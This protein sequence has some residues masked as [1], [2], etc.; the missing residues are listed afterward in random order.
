MDSCVLK[1]FEGLWTLAGGLRAGAG[2]SFLFQ[3]VVWLYARLGGS[4][5][6]GPV[7]ASRDLPE[8]VGGWNVPDGRGL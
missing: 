3:R 2:C 1:L 7:E 4:L 8:G 5:G 6:W